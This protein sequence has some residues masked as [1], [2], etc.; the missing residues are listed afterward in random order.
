MLNHRENQI[1]TVHDF[2]KLVDQ[3]KDKA[4]ASGNKADLIFRGQ[5]R[6]LPLLP[7]L[8]RLRFLA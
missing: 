4:I 6:D 2:V 1:D 3:A 8:S 7:K 5:R